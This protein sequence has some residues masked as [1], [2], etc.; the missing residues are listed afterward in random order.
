M[1]TLVERILNEIAEGNIEIDE[2]A[3]YSQL[4]P[5]GLPRYLGLEERYT[6]RLS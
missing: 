1:S 5:V 4:Y 6:N 2:R 3:I